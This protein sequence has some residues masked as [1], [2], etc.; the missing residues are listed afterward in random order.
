MST[1]SKRIYTSNYARCGESK[2]SISISAS[3]PDYFAG[4]HMTVLAPSW[5]LLNQ[6]KKGTVS[7]SMYKNEYIKLLEGR[8]LTPQ[9]V[10]DSIPHEAILLCYERAGEFCHRRILA[11]WL[12]NDL[13][14]RIP[15]WESDDE[16]KKSE[17]VDNVL[18]F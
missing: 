2:H 11:D 17:F 15:E 16:R 14:V 5:D 4:P 9:I 10:Y 13:N 12:E 8:K 18:D 3:A 6:Y 7:K 1:K